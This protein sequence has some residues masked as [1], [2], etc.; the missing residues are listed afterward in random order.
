MQV[1]QK[2]KTNEVS[3]SR[4]RF[5]YGFNSKKGGHQTWLK[6]CTPLP[7]GSKEMKKGYYSVFWKG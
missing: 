7:L 4:E 1:E 6:L 5:Y 2:A 3:E